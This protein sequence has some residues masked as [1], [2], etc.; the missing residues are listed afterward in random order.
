MMPYVCAVSLTDPV[1]VVNLPGLARAAIIFKLC[2]IVVPIR[3]SVCDPLVLL[4]NNLLT[5]RTNG[6]IRAIFRT[7][8]Q[9]SVFQLTHPVIWVAR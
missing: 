9:Q 6:G 5:G 1:T 8:A 3:T 7:K 2:L 4:G